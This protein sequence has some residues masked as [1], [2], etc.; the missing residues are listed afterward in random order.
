MYKRQL[1]AGAGCEIALG[2][3]HLIV[4]GR[5]HRGLTNVILSGDFEIDGSRQTISEDDFKNVGIVF[6]V[7]YAP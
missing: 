3:G 5:F 6:L 1:I 2:P 7:G 4:E